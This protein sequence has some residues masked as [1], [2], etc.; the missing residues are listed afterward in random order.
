MRLRGI[1][2]VGLAAI[3]ALALPLAAEAKPKKKKAATAKVMTR[4]LF[5]GADL[6][7]AI[8][9]GNI[10]EFLEANGAILNEVD[11]TDF[12][13]RAPALAAEIR[14]KK[15]DLVGL[16]EV[17][18]WR[19]AP[20]CVQPALTGEP[21]ATDV[22][23]DFLDLLLDQVNRGKKRYRVAVVQPEF[24]F[25][26]PADKNGMPGDGPP[27]EPDLES[28]NPFGVISDAELNGRLTMRDVI[29]VRKNRKRAKTKIKVKNPIAGHFENLLV[30]RVA[31]AVDV[32]VTRGWTALD[33]TVKK[34]KGKKQVKRKFRF[35]NT[36]FEAFDDET[37]TPSIRQ[38]QAQELAGIATDPV[39]GYAEGNKP[40][41][42]LGDLNSDDDTVVPD[43]Q[44]AY[45]ALLAAGFTERSTDDPLSCCVSDLFT[46]PPSEFDHQVD[47]VMTDQTP[48]RVRLVTSSVVGLAQVD[49]IYPSDHAGVVSKLKLK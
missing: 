43:D 13:R 8:N 33:A 12:P 25:E 47:H 17:A 46:S 34:G 3:M 44:K 9:S 20:P 32:P 10:G 41:I 45:R 14:K 35:F 27:A 49:G 26:A 28:C 5:L 37:E 19:T 11:E 30:V 23:Y 48:K 7:P 21:A 4:N 40:V 29:L 22:E 39:Y 1:V 6:A 31:N 36:H 38:L 2:V 24:D 16:Q 42:L 15:P 18:L